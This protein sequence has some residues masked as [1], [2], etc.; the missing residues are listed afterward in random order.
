MCLNSIKTKF[1]FFRGL[2]N[3]HCVSRLFSVLVHHQFQFSRPMLP[4][5]QGQLYYCCHCLRSYLPTC[6]VSFLANLFPFQVSECFEGRDER[7][8][9]VLAEP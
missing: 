7:R 1:I 3:A 4:P 9:C 6:Y 8:P 2:H 5:K